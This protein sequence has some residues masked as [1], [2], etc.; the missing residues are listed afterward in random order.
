MIEESLD[1]FDFFQKLSGKI[2]VYNTKKTDLVIHLI[3]FDQSGK[4]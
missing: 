1:K 2:S 3:F 4:F